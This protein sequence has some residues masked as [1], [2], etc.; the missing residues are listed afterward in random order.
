[1]QWTCSIGWIMRRPS[2]RAFCPEASRRSR[3]RI[4]PG[5]SI[6]PNIVHFIYLIIYC[7]GCKKRG[8]LYGEKF[9]VFRD[10]FHNCRPHAV[11]DIPGDNLHYIGIFNLVAL[12]KKY[13]YNNRHNPINYPILAERWPNEKGNYARVYHPDC[14]SYLL[15]RMHKPDRRSQQGSN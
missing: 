6:S 8:C 3:V 13:L 14:R 5:P 10:C 7:S 15:K 11:S 9:H 2:I 12:E 1:M 4:P